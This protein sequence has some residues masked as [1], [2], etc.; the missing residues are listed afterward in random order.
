[1]LYKK[2]YQ[3]RKIIRLVLFLAVVGVNSQLAAAQD[4]HDHN[5]NHAGKEIESEKILTQRE[6]LINAIAPTRCRWAFKQH[7]G[8]SHQVKRYD[9][10]RVCTFQVKVKGA[11]S[12]AMGSTALIPFNVYDVANP[13]KIK[14]VGS[15]QLPGAIGTAKIKIKVPK[16]GLM[17][18]SVR[19]VLKQ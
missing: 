19:E 8:L 1:M 12:M 14:L 17:R 3:V 15:S 18:L 11:N 9:I 2:P 10:D 13:D 6:L 5:G 16:K 7:S 4:S